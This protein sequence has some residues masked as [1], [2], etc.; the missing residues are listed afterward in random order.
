MKKVYKESQLIE[1]NNLQVEVIQSIRETIAIL[2]ESYG[3]ERDIEL[4]LGGYVIIAPSIVDIEMLKKDK[5]QG[6]IPEYTDVIQ[7][8]EG[9]KWTTS[10]FLLTSITLLILFY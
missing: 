10:L 7:C 3:E 9:V 1:L 4:D 5:L 8:S 6:L 2:N